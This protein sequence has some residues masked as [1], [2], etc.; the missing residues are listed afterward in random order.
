MTAGKTW[1]I[2]GLVA[3]AVLELAVAVAV[4]GKPQATGRQLPASE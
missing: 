1:F 4:A 3:L 2:W